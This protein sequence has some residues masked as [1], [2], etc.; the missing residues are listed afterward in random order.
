MQISWTKGFISPVSAPCTAFSESDGCCIIAV[1]HDP[2]SAMQ[3]RRSSRQPARTRSG[4]ED[5]TF[6]PTRVNGM[7]LYA[8]LLMDVWSRKIVG[9]EIN[10]EES[11]AHARAFFRRVA[12]A[13]NVDG[14][15]L[16]SDNGNPMKGVTILALFF[17]LGILLSYSRPPVSNDNPFSESLFKTIKFTPG[18]PRR[19]SDIDEARTWFAQFVDWYNTKHRHSGI[20]YMAPQDRHVGRTPTIMPHR[21]NVLEQAREKHPERWPNGQIH[22]EEYPVVYLNPDPQTRETLM[23]KTA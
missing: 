9:W 10:T 11:E 7:F 20:G 2:H 15:R 22:W 23:R 12:A 19:F 14:V 8:Y 21:N 13:N 4:G 3:N 1:N 6:F 5:I 17:S 18:Y 16:H